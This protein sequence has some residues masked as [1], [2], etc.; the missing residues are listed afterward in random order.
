MKYLIVCPERMSN[1]NEP[2]YWKANHWGYTMNREE[3]GRFSEE[4]MEKIC[5]QPYVD[6]FGVPEDVTNIREYFENKAREN[7]RLRKYWTISNG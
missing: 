5:N 7:I 2:V 6:D 4:E 1:D 3:A